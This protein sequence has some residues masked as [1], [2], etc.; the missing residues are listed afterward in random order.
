MQEFKYSPSNIDLYWA[1]CKDYGN[2]IKSAFENG[3]RKVNKRKVFIANAM[4][5][6]SVH[7]SA[8][9]SRAGFLA[10]MDEI[11]KNLQKKKQKKPELSLAEDFKKVWGPQMKIVFPI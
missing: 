3:S 6:W 7:R 4:A 9:D 11:N 1:I 5:Y 8:K 10:I 2:A